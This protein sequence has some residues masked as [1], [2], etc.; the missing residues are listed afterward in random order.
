M[1]SFWTCLVLSASVI[2][3]S[4]QSMPAPSQDSGIM[5]AAVSR[6]PGMLSGGIVS[7]KLTAKGTA[8]LEPLAWLTPSGEWRSLPCDA[9]NQSGCRKFERDYLSKPH[10]YTVVSA[11]GRGATINAAPVALGDCFEYTGT[12]TYSGAE[13]ERSAIAASSTNFFD[14]SPPP[15][16]LHDT[17]AIPVLKAF[18]ATVPGGADS[19]LQLRVFSLRLEGQGFVLLQRSYSEHPNPSV[20]LIFAIGAVDQGQFHLFHW[21]ENTGDEDEVALG[22]V[23]LTIGREF[24]I[25]TVSDPEG[26]W[27]R[28]YGIREGKLVMVYSGGGSSC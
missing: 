10:T 28:V 14:D 18:A 22:T 27:F 3:L 7:G 15:Q 19:T 21:K 2:A 13:I 20:K 25:T 5:L 1:S 24:L 8:A 12:A 16:L 11:D 23:H 9:K 4:Q 26:Q 6:H 17:A